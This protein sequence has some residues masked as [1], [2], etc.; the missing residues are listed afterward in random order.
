MNKTPG[1]PK[2]DS[3][4]LGTTLSVSK[5]AAMRASKRSEAEDKAE[6]PASHRAEDPGYWAGGI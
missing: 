1:K 3:S 2:Q 6:K 5:S 4:A